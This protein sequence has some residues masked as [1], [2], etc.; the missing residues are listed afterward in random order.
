M[1]QFEKILST[2]LTNS[3]N[4]QSLKQ[5]IQNHPSSGKVF[6]AFCKYYFIYEPTVKDDYKNVWYFEEIPKDIRQRLNFTTID[7]GVDLLLEN[8]DNQFIAIQCKF[9]SD[10]SLKLS[11]SKDKIANLFASAAKTDGFIVF[12]NATDIDGVSKLQENFSLCSI[13]HLLTIEESTFEAIKLHLEGK[14]VSKIIKYKPQGHQKDAIASCIEFFEIETRGQLIMPC[15]SGKTV[16]SLWIKEQLNPKNTL[17]VVPSLALLRQIKENWARQK[18]KIY[19][20]L[21]VCSETDIDKNEENETDTFVT[22]THEIVGRVTTDS[23]VILKFLQNDYEKVIFSTYQSLPQI[24]EAIQNTTFQFDFVLCDEAHKTASLTQGLFSI[25]HDNQR[26][27]ARKRLYMTATP[28][29]VSDNIKKKLNEELKYAY[30]MSNPEIFGYEFYR[31]TFKQAIEKGIL[32]DYKIITVGITDEQIAD[33]IK[34]RRFASNK[35]TVEDIANNYALETVMQRYGATHAIT[36]HSR[37]KYAFE[38]S[39]RHKILFNNIDSFHV[40]GTQSTNYR[41][42]LMNTFRNSSKAVI[43]NA[44]CL[45]EGIDVPAIDLVYFCDPKNS[46]V[47]IVQATGRALR[48]DRKKDKKLGYIVIPIYHTQRSEI[49][50]AISNSNFKNL[51]SVVRA[52]CDQDERL[53]DEINLLAYGKGKRS[54]FSKLEVISG[55]VFTEGKIHLLG[56]EEKLKANLFDQVIE[57]TSDNWDLWFLRF[58][59]YL[60]DNNNEYPNLEQ[61]P[62]I[63]RWIASQRNAK[64]KKQLSVEQIKQLN[65]RNFIWDGHEQIWNFQFEKLKKYSEENKFEPSHL[66]ERDLA[67]WYKRQIKAIE[68]KELSPFQEK[69]IFS[70]QF[71]GSANDL[72]WYLKYESLKKYSE[73]NEFEPESR[74]ELSI[75][76]NTQKQNIKKGTLSEERKAQILSLQFKGSTTE[77]N[78]LKHFEELLRFRVKNP[79]KFP[80]YK[81]VGQEQSINELGIFC[82]TMRKR[83]RENSLSD[84]W[85]SKLI[86]INFNFDGHQDNWKATYGTLVKY[87][88]KHQKLPNIKSNLYSWALRNRNQYEENYLS[89]ERKKLWEEL[90]INHL[91]RNLSRTW[92]NWYDDVKAYYDLTNT[93]PSFNQE[94]QLGAWLSTQRGLFK[95]GELNREQ[96]TKLERLEIVWDGNEEKK[97]RW[98]EQFEAVVEFHKEFKRFPTGRSNTE[99]QKLYNWCQGQR[100]KQ[101]GT[102]T[103]GRTKPLSDW[104]VNQLKEIGRAS[105]RERVLNLV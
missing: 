36:F 47:D 102:H 69:L 40:S 66:T 91:F 25:I 76:Y 28:R 32:I 4:W 79:N 26:I 59:E 10:E 101:A 45:T 51:I 48:Q 71:K 61:S 5:V 67:N 95:K 84:Y 7:H 83:Y 75:W 72:K 70:I 14:T 54:N 85:I 96:I 41:N 93:L 100:Q 21:C 94:K 90:N 8:I 80:Q 99:E 53:Q 86:E 31:M 65:S 58:K 43:S 68:Q 37:V 35:H 62:S 60:N 63:Y 1:K 15:G 87:V 92:N 56:F 89:K 49:E 73:E 103:S 23:Q 29:V 98:L 55:E 13:S 38:F 30:D 34:E 20:Y 11:W 2:S 16:T 78:W 64:K 82:Q 57:K 19:H 22:H 88:N 105:C 97:E 81:R 17:V 24:E 74:S 18:N 50:K 46:K 104:Q 3:N 44:R 33:Y 39:E 27:P 6:E 52:L 12:T 77:N 42:A 9:R